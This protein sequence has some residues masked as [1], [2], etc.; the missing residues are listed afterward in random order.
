MEAVG[1]ESLGEGVSGGG[2]GEY[3]SGVHQMNTIP[4]VK[5]DATE[6]CHVSGT[7][8]EFLWSMQGLFTI[9]SLN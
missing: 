4:D 2:G 6:L 1:A 8:W 9:G 3:V 7:F 5:H